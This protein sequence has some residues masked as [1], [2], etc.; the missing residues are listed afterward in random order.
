MAYEL[1]ETIKNLRKRQK[2]TQKELAKILDVTESTISKYE[3]NTAMPTFE[4]LRTI[5]VTFHVSMDTLCGISREETISLQGMSERQKQT[6]LELT[7]YFRKCNLPFHKSDNDEKF[8]I[9][10]K[11]TNEL[12]K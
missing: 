4:A 6:I 10:G 5:A 1:G 8:L 12:M 11:I 2:M 9:L 7:A 3:S